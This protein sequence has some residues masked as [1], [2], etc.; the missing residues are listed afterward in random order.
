MSKSTTGSPAP[1]VRRASATSGGWFVWMVGMWV[2]FF[3]LLNAG[4]LDDLAGWIRDL[5]IL[6]EILVWVAFFPW[7]LGTA[8]WTSGWSEG[9][10]ITLVVLFA[11]VWIL[12]SIPRPRK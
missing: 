7:V 8:V 6:L 2:A 5:P 3:V 11:A 12:I 10:R 1:E 4:R 9:L